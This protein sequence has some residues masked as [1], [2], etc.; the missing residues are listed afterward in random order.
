MYIQNFPVK[1]LGRVIVEPFVT[2][3][4]PPVTIIL[5]LRMLATGKFQCI[6]VLKYPKILIYIYHWII[7][8]GT[9]DNKNFNQTAKQISFY[10]LRQYPQK[11]YFDRNLC[12][13]CKKNIAWEKFSKEHFLTWKQFLLF[14]QRHSWEQSLVEIKSHGHSFWEFE[15]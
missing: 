14:R 12:G 2:N 7:I 6:T 3:Q 13:N 10:Y 11:Y 1:V 8:N 15:Y 9:H 5:A 4:L